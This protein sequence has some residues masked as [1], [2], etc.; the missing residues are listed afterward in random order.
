MT[1]TIATGV[2]GLDDLLPGGLPAGACTVVSGAAGTGKTTLAGHVIAE[3]A[4]R[5]E[6]G[7]DVSMEESTARLTEHFARFG[8]PMHRWIDEGRWRFLDASPTGGGG[9]LVV[10][11]FDF[12]GL[13][14]RIRHAVGETGARRV[15]LD[16]L[17]ALFLQFDDQAAVRRELVGLA[18]SLRDL[19]VTAVLTTEAQEERTAKEYRVEDFIADA[20]LLLRNVLDGQRRRRTVEV[21][22]VRGGAHRTGEYPFAVRPDDGMTTLSFTSSRPSSASPTEHVGTGNGDLDQ[23]LGG[24]LHRDAVMLVTGATGTGKTSLAAQFASLQGDGL[25]GV[26]VSFEES[27]SQLERNLTVEQNRDLRVHAV[28]AEDASP[29]DHLLTILD[30]LDETR[31]SRLAVDSLSALQRV[32]SQQA[33]HLFM[34]GLANSTKERGIPLLLTSNA[35]RMMGDLSITSADISTT[36]DVII[37]LRYVEWQGRI[38]RALTVLKARALDHDRRLFRY[39]ATPGGLRIREPLDALTGILSGHPAPSAGPQNTPA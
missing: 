2:P 29:D 9:E 39:D 19:G 38:E 5:D 14:A 34:R 27:R 10:G 25:P 3:G 4:R 36:T 16:A 33:L 37:L 26:L 30:L 7:V 11:S 22:K 13:I 15:V 24:G 35:H 20:V 21:M 28:S 1:D 23:L 31:A 18:N 8:W 6:P 32:A 12:E 17:S